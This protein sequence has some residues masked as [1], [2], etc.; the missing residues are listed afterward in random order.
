MLSRGKKGLIDL[1]GLKVSTK[2]IMN[3]GLLPNEVVL[4]IAGKTKKEVLLDAIKIIDNF[5]P[6]LNYDYTLPDKNLFYSWVYSDD[7]RN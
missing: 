7:L 5:N 2:K 4:D 6:V 1:E 3:R